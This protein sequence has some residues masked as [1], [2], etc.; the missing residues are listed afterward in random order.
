M[1]RMAKSKPQKEG[2]GKAGTGSPENHL[3]IRPHTYDR[4]LATLF[5]TS[6]SNPTS[7]LYVFINDF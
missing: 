2:P 1:A 7:T 5:A 4:A 6:V 3:T